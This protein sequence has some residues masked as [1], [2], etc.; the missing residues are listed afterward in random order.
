MANFFFAD[1]ATA[2]ARRDARGRRRDEGADAR[3]RAGGEVVRRHGRARA[4]RD[5]MVQVRA[6]DD[7]GD[8][9]ARR[10]AAGRPT[11]KRRAETDGANDP[12]RATGAMDWGKDD[13]DARRRSRW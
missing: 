12:A 6:T 9:R 1:L 5:G 3:R 2:S 7:R 10:P 11:P 8:R 4:A 13:T